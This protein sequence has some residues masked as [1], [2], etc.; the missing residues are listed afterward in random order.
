LSADVVVPVNLDTNYTDAQHNALN[1]WN[2][3][4][5]QISLYCKCCWR[6]CEAP[7]KRFYILL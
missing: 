2:R 1:T 6:C 3:N 4:Y 5:V 7:N